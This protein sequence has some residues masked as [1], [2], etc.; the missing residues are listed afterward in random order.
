MSPRP[1]ADRAPVL[2]FAAVLAW[3]LWAAF[4]MAGQTGLTVWADRDLM[5]ALTAPWQAFG[6]EINGGARPP[7]GAFYLLLAGFL[8]VDPTIVS[9]H[10]GLLTLFAL[11]LILLAVEFGRQSTAGAG[12]AAAVLLAGSPMLGDVLAIWNPGFVLFFATAAT[13]WG[14]RFLRRGEFWSL[15][16]AAAA[17]AIGLQ[18]HLQMWIPAAALVL[19]LPVYRPRCDR[20]HALALFLG[21]ILPFLP[22]LAAGLLLPLP[23]S[24]AATSGVAGNYLWG[25]PQIREKLML[26]LALL[27]GPTAAPQ[28]MTPWSAI[29]LAADLTAVLVT[30]AGLAAPALRRRFATA[31]LLLAV[32]LALAE[33]A[34]ASVN[35]RH[36]VAA[37]PALACLGGLGVD[38]MLGWTASRTGSRWPAG[39]LAA[40]VCLLLAARPLGLAAETLAQPAFQ[41]GS[42]ALQA[43]MAAAVKASITT[44]P[45]AFDARTA[46]FWRPRPGSWQLVQEGVGG[47]MAFIF[48][49]TPAVPLGTATTGCLAVIHK[50]DVDA[51][52]PASL[53]RSPAFAGLAPRFGEAVAQSV[54]FLVLPYTTAD[55][56][57]LKSFPNAYVPSRQEADLPNPGQPD[58]W[59][60][61]AD[62]LL[63]AT[64]LP[65]DPFPIGLLLRRDEQPGRFRA[66]LIGRPL[67]GYTGLGFLT[68]VAPS[69]CLV[70]KDGAHRV[71][72]ASLTVGS[73]QRGTLAPWQSPA[74]AGPADPVPAWLIGRDG[75]TSR[76]VVR[77]LGQI[78]FGDLSAAAAPDPLTP[79]PPGCPVPEG[80]G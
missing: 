73:P 4:H 34:L 12:W 63:F 1:I 76:T 35:A 13:V 60:R 20:R 38:R 8:A 52:T 67:R 39:G 22:S 71:P 15:G 9:V 18:I 72:L 31:A 5:R 53:A 46:L 80:R 70:D 50:S 29:R 32:L 68:L 33:I 30:A 79:P 69:L 47:Q 74:F 36:L 51:D 21:L 55:G 64:H 65:D 78:D 24:S 14:H 56:N 16:L 11:S 27:G 54:H 75:K 10:L 59:R 19:A 44:D 23:V 58:S 26:T 66:Q 62:G 61:T 45:D 49:T 40:L 7:G 25:V 2:L 48:R 6:P 43:E 77:A 37:L 41:P 3:H 42:V 28:T 57:C 17:I